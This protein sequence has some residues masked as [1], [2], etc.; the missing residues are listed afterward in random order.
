[1]ASGADRAGLGASSPLI[2]E[3]DIAG[4]RVALSGDPQAVPIVLVHGLAERWQVWGPLIPLLA[5][6]FRVIAVD[7]PGFGA[8][9]PLA[10]GRFPLDAVA[11]RLDA[12]LAALEVERP[13]LCGHSLGG[14]LC[15]FAAA[16]DPS[17]Y[18]AVVLIA[19]A[20]LI[21]TGAVR[22]SWRRPRVHAATR[23]LLALAQPLANI[24][25]LRSRVFARLAVQTDRIDGAELVA[26]ARVARSTPAAGVTIVHAGLRDRLHRLTLP[27]LVVWGAQDRVIWPGF[28]EP[29]AEALPDARLLE[30]E[31]AGHLVFVENPERV[32][33]AIADLVRE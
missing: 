4:L 19:P 12:T 17:R 16:R 7:L 24:P 31:D 5:E 27:A 23:R 25:A 32:A 11:D 2:E 15:V 6:S 20:G 10:G 30:D 14:G 9:P 1:M 21:A 18:R 28:A 13:V 8:S 29:L 33:A 26:G 22:P 3:R